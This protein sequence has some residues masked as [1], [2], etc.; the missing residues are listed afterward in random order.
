[1]QFEVLPGAQLAIQRIALG[2]EADPLARGQ[3]ASI[4]R[5]AKQTGAALAGRHQAGE[6]LHGGGLAAAV[7]AEETEDLAAADGEADLVHRGE[8]AETQGQVVGLDGNRPAVGLAWRDAQGLGLWSSG[9]LEV[10]EGVVQLAAGRNRRQFA[11]EAGGQQAASVEHQ[12]M[13]ELL[14]LLHVS[15]GHQQGQLRALGAHLL[16]QL[17]EAPP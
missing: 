3:V 2:H 9:A 4:H 11:A 7:G 5:A 13:L 15:G 14:C 6:H 1:V 17:P 8:V 12:A 10:G 16:D